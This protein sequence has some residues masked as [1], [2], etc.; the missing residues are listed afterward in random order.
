MQHGQDILDSL[1]EIKIALVGRYGQWRENSA[2][3]QFQSAPALVSNFLPQ[4]LVARRGVQSLDASTPLPSST[5]SGSHSRAPM[6]RSRTPSPYRQSPT[7]DDKAWRERADAI[8]RDEARRRGETSVGGV[9]PEQS[10]LA[11]EDDARRRRERE[12]EREKHWLAE[13]SRHEQI[14]ILRRQQEAEFAAPAARFGQ[15]S[16]QNQIVALIPQMSVQYPSVPGSVTSDPA[17]TGKTASHLQMPLE[18]LTRY[19]IHQLKHSSLMFY[20]T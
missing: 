17:P 14:G 12:E 10:R 9:R 15:P 18:S 13:Q 11:R 4:Q 1:A 3:A 2:S 16:G 5:P 20:G 7:E 6:P 8:P 19:V